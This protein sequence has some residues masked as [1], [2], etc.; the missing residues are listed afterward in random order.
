MKSRTLSILSLSLALALLVGCASGVPQTIREGV[1]ASP[2]L[3]EVQ[4][5]PER[6]LGRRVRWG[7]SIL[8]VRNLARTTEIEVLA[9]PLDGLG[10]PDADAK[11]MGR[12]MIEFAG[13][14]DPAEYPKERLLTVV[15][16]LVKVETRPVGDF[17]YPYPVVAMETFYLWPKPIRYLYP[18]P[19]PYSY[20]WYGPW[21]G[22]YRAPWYDPWFDPWY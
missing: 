4:Q 18:A 1:A 20:P 7:G 13:F 21:P 11:G 14:K 19:Y 17:Q 9:R 3:A 22:F 10:E 12:F 8:A 16:T 15:G 5:H 6:Y 2:S